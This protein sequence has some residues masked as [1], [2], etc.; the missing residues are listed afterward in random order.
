MTEIHSI[1]STF[2]YP[3]YEGISKLPDAWVFKYTNATK[4]QQLT[5]HKSPCDD[6][7]Q[8]SP[9]LLRRLESAYA[10]KGPLSW[11]GDPRD[12]DE[13]SRREDQAES[14]PVEI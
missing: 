12:T 4:G 6:I 14:T 11:S 1:L 3:G 8:F 10:Q 7:P 5:F 13:T 2:G 9:D